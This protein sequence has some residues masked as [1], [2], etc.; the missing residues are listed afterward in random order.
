[1]GSNHSVC[2]LA[3]FAVAAFAVAAVVAA[4][5]ATLVAG[6]RADHC[7]CACC[8]TLSNADE[9]KGRVANIEHKVSA[10]ATT[11]MVAVVVLLESANAASVAA[12]EI[13]D[14]ENRYLFRALHLVTNLQFRWPFGTDT[15]Y[16]YRSCN[17]LQIYR[18]W[19]HTNATVFGFASA[20]PVFHIDIC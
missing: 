8:T 5:V 18:H 11:G 14:I 3:C 6:G 10:A 2:L 4:A 16:S 13:S 15:I 1:V 19:L 17:W 12:V 20:N 7:K 9:C